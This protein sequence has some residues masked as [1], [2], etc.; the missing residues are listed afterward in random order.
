MGRC[1][2]LPAMESKDLVLFHLPCPHHIYFLYLSSPIPIHPPIKLYGNLINFNSVFILIC[3]MLSHI[4]SCGYF[5]SLCN[6]F[7]FWIDNCLLYLFAWFFKKYVYYWSILL[8]VLLHDSFS[9][10]PVLL[11]LAHVGRSPGWLLVLGETPASAGL[12]SGSR[13]HLRETLE[14]LLLKKRNF[15]LSCVAFY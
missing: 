14:F 3:L 7:R 9:L 12:L 1:G 11:G 2:K 13:P 5:L 15:L 10:A 6:F 8:E 4:V